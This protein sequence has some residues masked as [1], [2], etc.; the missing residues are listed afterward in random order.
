MLQINCGYARTAIRELTPK[1]KHQLTPTTNQHRK[2]EFQKLFSCF[3]HPYNETTQHSNGISP[4]DTHCA[5]VLTAFSKKWNP[6][7]ARLDYEKQF[8]IENWKALTTEKQQE[9]SLSNCIACSRNH[10]ELQKTF[11][12]GPVY[13]S[14]SYIAL[15]L[16]SI[17]EGSKRS[18][19]QEVRAVL[20]ELNAQWESRYD[21]K[22]TSVLPTMAP[23]CNLARK[24]TRV[25][26]KRK[27]TNE[28]ENSYPY[29]PTDEGECDTNSPRRE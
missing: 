14:P 12:A 15:S 19:K 8:S 21:H 9:H 10:M 4:F 11:P 26:V 13:N 29:F 18:E 2:C 1:C 25:E 17:T 7:Q 24:Q 22:I 5:K 3:S 23:E 27:E 16:P 28:E 6:P 20:G